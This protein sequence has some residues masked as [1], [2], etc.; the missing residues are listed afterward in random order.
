[1][2]E[3]A[4]AAGCRVANGLGLLLYPGTQALELWSGRPAPVDV[5]RRGLR[6]NVYG[7]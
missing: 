6:E 5:M 1:L 3:A 2:L 4:R 7:A